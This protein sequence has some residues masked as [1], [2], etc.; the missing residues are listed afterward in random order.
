MIPKIIH[1]CWLSGDPYPPKIRMCLESWKKH[2][3]DYKIWLWDLNRFDINSSRWCKEAF[4]AKKYAFAAD[5]IRCY[6]LYNYG[7][8]YLDSDV[9]VL[10]PYDD[11][12]DIPYFCGMENFDRAIEMATFGSEKGY[13]P[14]KLMMDFYDKNNF[15][16]SDGTFNQLVC[17]EVFKS[18]TKEAGY[19]TKR[20]QNKG[21][22]VNDPKTI[23]ALPKYY[24]SPDEFDV[25]KE[26][27]S[28]H[29]FQASW[30]TPRYRKFRKIAEMIFGKKLKAKLAYWYLRIRFGKEYFK[31]HLN[32]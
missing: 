14:F 6:A 5:Y 25:R 7:G 9:E 29:H 30:F 4:D 26:T 24:F 21:E 1:L 13:E 19:T 31:D 10:K 32:D 18:V 11:L 27:Y 8:I 28:I 3:P 20:I 22:F 15:I 17:P 23:C 12:L 16:K 2:L